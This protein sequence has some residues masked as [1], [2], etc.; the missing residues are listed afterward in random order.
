[1]KLYMAVTADK[2]ELPLVISRRI[3]DVAEYANAPLSSVF[4][5]IT[6]NVS[7][8]RRGIKFVKVEI[9]EGDVI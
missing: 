2:Y 1:M 6:K 3:Q 4:S 8:K 5:G 9:D 7:G